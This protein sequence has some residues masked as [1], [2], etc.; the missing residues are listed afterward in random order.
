[1]SNF[2]YLCF[3]DKVMV[4]VLMW[5]GGMEQHVI[6]CHGINRILLYFFYCI[7]KVVLV[8]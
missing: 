4:I 6:T 2:I 5:G 7:L 8:L 3:L 1:M